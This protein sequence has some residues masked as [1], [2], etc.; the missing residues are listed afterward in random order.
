VAL[1]SNLNTPALYGKEAVDSVKVKVNAAKAATL[2]ALDNR[3][4]VSPIS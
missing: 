1:V 3:F 2:L 4:I